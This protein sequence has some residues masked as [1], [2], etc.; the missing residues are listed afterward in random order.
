M[1]L[2]AKFLISNDA[3]PP[4][5]SQSTDHH[6]KNLVSMGYYKGS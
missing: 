4:N 1:E 2:A 3:V 6:F 5:F